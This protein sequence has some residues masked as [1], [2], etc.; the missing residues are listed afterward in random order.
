MTGFQKF[1]SRPNESAA[2]TCYCDW[3]ATRYG[4]IDE[5]FWDEHPK[6]RR[7][8]KTAT[9]LA[10]LGAAAHIGCQH[11]GRAQKNSYSTTNLIGNSSNKW[12]KQKWSDIK[13]T[14]SELADSASAKIKRAFNPN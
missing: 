4:G 8:V 5:G 6:T 13:D 10:A 2:E 7:L 3:L 12:L 1:L 14:G 11:Q 9:A